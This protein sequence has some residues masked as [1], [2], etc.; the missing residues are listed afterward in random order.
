MSSV[1]LT[2]PE[3]LKLFETLPGAELIAVA[4]TLDA[5]LLGVANTLDA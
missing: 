1:K 2:N 5:D 4:G 3:A